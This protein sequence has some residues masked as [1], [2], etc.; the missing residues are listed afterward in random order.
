MQV[1]GIINSKNYEV[2]GI[3]LNM[4]NATIFEPGMKKYINIQYQ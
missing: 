1:Q 3:V 2:T 4:Q